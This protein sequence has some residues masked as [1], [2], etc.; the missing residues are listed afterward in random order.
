MF[1][2]MKTVHIISLSYYLYA[3]IVGLLMIFVL[4]HMLYRRRTPTSIVAWLLS[5]I[6][7]PYIAIPLYFFIGSRKQ[8]RHKKSFIVMNTD[9]GSIC[10]YTS[11]MDKVLRNDGIPQA[12][13]QN[14]I[15]LYTDGVEAYKVILK[16]IENAKD[17]IYICTYIFDY[18]EATKPIFKLLIKKAREGVD[19]K[20]L[21]DGVGSYK[22]YLNKLHTKILKRAGVELYFF[23]PL[24][25]F[26]PNSYINLRNHRKIY[27]FDKSTVLS[28][29]MNLSKDYINRKHT[30][31]LMKDLL[32]LLKGPAMYRYLEIFVSD[33]KHVSGRKLNTFI[34]FTIP[35]RENGS[36]IVQV[37]P[38][39]PDLN[40]DAL[41]EA[42]MVAIY[43]AKNRIWIVTPYFT[44][45]ITLMRALLIAKRRGV[46]VKL[47]TPMESDH[48]LADLVRSSYMRE[49]E[50]NKAH[51]ALYSKGMLH[52]KAVLFDDAS[53][54]LGSVNFDSRSLFLNYEVAS[55]AYSKKIIRD[56]ELWMLSLLKDSKKSMNPAGKYRKMAENFMRIF[57]PQI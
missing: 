33:W 42:L 7:I 15:K 22:L 43:E 16:E 1:N 47:I 56:V 52:A 19:V 38:S 32:F 25:S 11:P 37:V 4:M 45:D 23:M 26:P 20:L 57:A 21:L 49:L 51:V 18:D 24:L 46:D 41:F 28:G 50:E 39:G 12:T 8:K 35:D 6:F 2:N 5:I 13:C 53:V 40:G 14:M 29:G 30:K 44:P 3:I 34:K 55:F 17:S 54:L 27:I 9:S 48:I 31:H 36:D 10:N